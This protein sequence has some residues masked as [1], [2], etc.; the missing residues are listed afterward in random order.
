MKSDDSASKSLTDDLLAYERGEL[1]GVETVTLFQQLID[2]G[3]VW[4]LQ[5]AYGR[6]AQHLIETGHCLLAP[7]AQRDY[8]GNVVPSRYDVEP[9]APGTEEFVHRQHPADEEPPFDPTR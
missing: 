4:T 6:M 7:V 5:G 1:S 2:S 9:G 8:F 3:Q